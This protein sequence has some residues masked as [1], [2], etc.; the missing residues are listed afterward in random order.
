MF[1]SKINNAAVAVVMTVL[2]IF[3]TTS[4]KKDEPA[5]T[6]ADIVIADPQFSV[7]KNA[8]TKANLVTTFQNAGTYTVFAP[9]NAA[10]AAVGIDQ[11]YV[12]AATT[13]AA[14]LIP[15]LSYH[16]LPKKITAAE[17][18]TA[19]NTEVATLLL[20][21]VYVTKNASGVSINGAKV[22]TADVT[23]SNGVIHIIDRALVPPTQDIVAYLQGKP[24][25][26]LLVAA[27]VKADL[28]NTLQGI[29]PLTVLAPNN[30]AFV[31]LGAPYSTVA[32]INNATAAQVAALK[33]ILLYHVISARAFSTNLTAGAL[34]T[35][36]PTK[37]VTID[38]TNGVK[39]I[40]GTAANVA[41]VV[42][43]PADRFN[44]LTTNGVIHTIDKVLIP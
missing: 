26:S 7:L 33:N 40:G 38:L 27:V 25:Y 1:L 23:A 16:V 22:T 6:I 19:N 15:I 30:A 20:G 21:T 5:K 43:S 12:D 28:V 42:T 9:T 29:G 8:L 3:S 14:Q 13:T 18:A 11:A 31:A 37:S 32:G 17:I 36:F 41:N 44:I 35:A 4:C 39:V 34:P 2:T 24:D 10:L